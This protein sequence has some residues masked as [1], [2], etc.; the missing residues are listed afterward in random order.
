MITFNIDLIDLE[1]PE[2]WNELSDSV[3]LSLS[4]FIRSGLSA[5]EIKTKMVLTCIGGR[6]IP[7]KHPHQANHPHEKKVYH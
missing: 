7:I 5:Q 2:N 6:V 4:G 3:L 1:I